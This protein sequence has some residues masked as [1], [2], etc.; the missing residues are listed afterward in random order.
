MM[1]FFSRGFAEL[2]MGHLHACSLFTLPTAF[3]SNI[4]MST[5]AVRVILS[6]I[7]FTSASPAPNMRMWSLGDCYARASPQGYNFRDTK[8]SIA[9]ETFFNDLSSACATDNNGNYPRA[10]DCNNYMGQAERYLDT[11]YLTSDVDLQTLYRYLFG[12]PN[13]AGKSS[14]IQSDYAILKQINLTVFGNYSTNPKTPGLMKDL[15]TLLDGIDEVGAVAGGQ[16]QSIRDAAR[17]QTVAVQMLADQMME[18]ATKIKDST[19]ELMGYLIGNRTQT[20][21]DSF[22]ELRNN[23]AEAVTDVEQQ[24]AQLSASF[25]NELD[26]IT[27][28]YNEWTDLSSKAIADVKN[29]STTLRS[30]TADATRESNATSKTFKAAMANQFTVGVANSAAQFAAQFTAA[31]QGLAK[32]IRDMGDGFASDIAKNKDDFQSMSGSFASD[33]SSQI[34]ALQSQAGGE[35]QINN[36]NKADAIAK[37]AASVDAIKSVIDTTVRPLTDEV[38]NSLAK[39]ADLKKAITDAKSKMMTDSRAIRTTAQSDASQLD[40]KIVQSFASAGT[41]FDAQLVSVRSQM[42]SDM[43]NK[44]SAGKSKLSEILGGIR[45]SQSD[46]ASQQRMAGKSASQEA[47]VSKTAA[48][49]AGAKQQSAADSTQASLTDM[50]KFVS[51]ALRDSQST[52]QDV[53]KAQLQDIVNM[54]RQLTTGEQDTLRKAYEQI[55]SQQKSSTD[56]TAKSRGDSYSAQLEGQRLEHSMEQVGTNLQGSVDYQNRQAQV[57][58]GEINDMLSVAKRNSGTLQDQMAAFEKQAPALFEVLKQKIAAYKAIVTAQGQQ[59][60]SSAASAVGAGAIN[61]L[62]GATGAIGTYGT[63]SSASLQAGQKQIQTDS[64]ALMSDITNLDSKL[65]QQAQAGSALVSNSAQA[66]MSKS[67]AELKTMSADSSN[68]IASLLTYNAD[69]VKSKQAEI[70]TS[71]DAAMNSVLKAADYVTQSANNFADRSRDFVTDAQNLASRADFNMTKMTQE[72]QA[73]LD[74]AKDASSRYLQRLTETQRDIGKWTGEITVQAGKINAVIQAKS[75]EISKAIAN[76]KGIDADSANQVKSSAQGLQTYIDSLI[77]AFEA[78]RASFNDFAL[79]YS[80][81]RLAVI[82]GLSETVLEQ[83]AAFLGDVSVSDLYESQRTAQTT[84]VIQGL[85]MAVEKAKAQGG[86]DMDRVKSMIAKIGNGVSGVTSTLMAQMGTEVSRLSDKATNDAIQS[87]KQMKTTVDATGQLAGKIGSDFTAALE[88]I[89][90][91]ENAAKQAQSQA[92]K[93]VYTIASLLKSTGQE[94]QQKVLALLKQIES[95]EK[96]VDQALAAAKDMSGAQVNTVQDVIEA[97][98]S[99]IGSHLG[100]VNKFKTGITGS[101]TAITAAV[102]RTIGD[103]EAIQA[104]TVGDMAA[105]AKRLADMKSRLLP[106]A[107]PASQ[108]GLIKQMQDERDSRLDGIEN[109]VTSVVSGSASKTAT[110]TSSSS[111]PASRSTGG[112]FLQKE[113]TMAPISMLDRDTPAVTETLPDAIADVETTLASARTASQTAK[114]QADS[115]VQTKITAATAA[116]NSIL[117]ATASALGVSAISNHITV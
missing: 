76:I 73:S 61:A 43:T 107:D 29:R 36:A 49:F 106:G 11:L 98:S 71:G 100:N 109:Y 112:V 46:A 63:T 24:A 14:I 68:A 22:S 30:R 7:A 33:M 87:G 75:A 8:T 12:C 18:Q 115:D 114:A 57:L 99:Y 47:T 45:S 64:A 108:P 84:S 21:L 41:Q 92:N 1:E 70:A 16:Q 90:K 53:N 5:L 105:D 25:V 48:E 51:G 97:F 110:I 80:I 113:R 74:Q 59:S 32:E 40:M 19:L 35:D 117:D 81:K 78:Q 94:T 17:S 50:I 31:Q 85:L 58:L 26:E 56:R 72:L 93:D 102:K 2:V 79:K 10:A 27:R 77:Q 103:H 83:K 67:L 91:G 34:A 20:Q 38:K 44:V 39:I 13:D 23:V 95:G 89:T 54:N 88:S 86:V 3:T 42:E 116:I 82:T 104:D 65:K 55:Q 4:P 101:S 62:S 15:L 66:G 6:T 37:V 60:Q 111:A 69:L 28:R 52:L 9:P 96:S